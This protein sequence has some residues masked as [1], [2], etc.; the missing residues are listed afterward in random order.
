MRCSARRRW[1]AVGATLL[2]LVGAS[3]VSAEH[4][5]LDAVD[6]QRVD[7]ELV[8]IRDGAS[9]VRIRL[10]K[11]EQVLWT[12]TDGNVAAVLTDRRFLAIS[13]SAARWQQFRFG[14]DDVEPSVWLG[15][16]LALCLT[17]RRVLHFAGQPGKVSETALSPGERVVSVAT[18]ERVG[19][20]VTDRRALGFS[21]D[22]NRVAERPFFVQET[23][24]ALRTRASSSTIRTSQRLLVF[25]RSGGGWIEER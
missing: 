24:E 12:G 5:T 23:F 13:R 17:P 18:D 3:A 4:A 7:D 11:G 16:N 1:G 8:G 6:V 19:A 14:R 15:A 10:L 25:K 2:A 9:S 22:D 21:S 20:V